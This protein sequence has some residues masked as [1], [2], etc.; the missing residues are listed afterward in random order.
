MQNMKMEELCNF[1]ALIIHMGHEQR[2]KLIIIDPGTN[3]RPCP[4]TFKKWCMVI[5]FI[6]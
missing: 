2:D 3:I 5:F 6:Y 4:F 1:L